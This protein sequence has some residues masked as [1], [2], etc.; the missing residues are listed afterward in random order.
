MKIVIFAAEASGDVLAADL[1]KE[2]K[3]KLPDCEIEGITGPRMLYAG[4]KS[5]ASIDELSVMGVVEVVKKLPSILKLRKRLL[6]ILLKNLPDL[7][8]GVDAPDFNLGI[9]KKLKQLGVPTVQY[10]SPTVWAWRKGRMK[11]IK[12]ATNMVLSILPFEEEFYKKYQH[13]CKFVGH[14]MA[15]KIPLRVNK[16]KAKE[17][18]SL[19]TNKTYIALLPGSRQQEFKFLLKPFLETA[20]LLAKQSDNIGF[21]LPLANQK[22]QV[23]LDKHKA[24]LQTLPIQIFD[25]SASQ[26]LQAADLALITSGTATLEAMLC[27]TPMVVAYKMSFINHQI[28]KMLVKT[29]YFSLPNLLANSRLVEELLQQKVTAENLSS[30]LMALM[31]SPARQNN[32]Q[33]KFTDLH[34]IL[35]QHASKKAAGVVCN[36]LKKT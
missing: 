3:K 35:K 18:L 5:L 27:K 10:V 1:I 9:A 24:L 17:R 29:K 25:N 22:L 21:L 16:I 28:A 11:L 13:P 14:P 6:A 20:A 19:D 8:I 15:D 2:I 32:L 26:V 12:Q 4:C 34:K 31:Q 7:F 36:I 33:K 23:E 30:S